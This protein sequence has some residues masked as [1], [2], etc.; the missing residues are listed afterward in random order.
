MSEFAESSLAPDGVGHRV[1]SAASLP[2]TNDFAKA[3][4]FTPADC[5]TIVLADH[6]TAGRGQYG[7]VW[8]SRPGASVLMSVV[9][10]PPVHLCRPVLLT[11]WAA[12][13]VG[14]AVQV[15]AGVTP[16]IK[17]PNDLLVDG[18]KLAGI[19][20]E[21]VHVPGQPGRV[22]AGIGLNVGQTADELANAG[23]TEA[24]SVVDDRR[25]GGRP[26]GGGAGT[27][28]R[29]AG[30]VS[31]VVGVRDRVAEAEFEAMTGL[32]GRRATVRLWD[33][34]TRV[35]RIDV[36]RFD[37]VRSL[38]PAVAPESIR[39]V[40]APTVSAACS[41]RARAYIVAVLPTVAPRRHPPS[42]PIPTDAPR[43]V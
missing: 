18:K 38:G 36:R 40:N 24:A 8:L 33:G 39:A 20:I 37:R 19:L 2:S 17:W 32:V 35:G 26:G 11:A 13:S 25:P 29:I 42:D 27:G 9:L 5:G 15:A 28:R 43:A 21:Q 12:V 4:P 10:F 7:R 1:L 31:T 23:L 34:T 6:Q 22:V 30:W 3:A 41:R 14:R 16:R